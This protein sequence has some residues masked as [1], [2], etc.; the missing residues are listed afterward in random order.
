MHR[1]YTITL[2]SEITNIADAIADYYGAGNYT[3]HY[4]TAEYLVFEIPAVC[5]KVIRIRIRSGADNGSIYWGDAWTSGTTITN[6][7]GLH[8]TLLNF[9]IGSHLLLSQ[10]SMCI[11]FENVR[12]QIWALG[13]LNDGNFISF[14]A[15]NHY[16]DYG[17]NRLSSDNSLIHLYVPTFPNSIGRKTASNKIIKTPI[18]FLNSSGNIAEDTSN[19]PLYFKD[20]FMSSINEKI[21][22]ADNIFIWTYAVNWYNGNYNNFGTI[23][24]ATFVAELDNYTL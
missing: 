22:N 6:E 16:Y 5:D 3:I 4:Q 20:V 8:N 10:Y 23:P 15:S 13:Q 14:S 12:S 17:I 18:Y 2:N 19:E 11:F 9:T 21:T 24:G 1:K 7:V